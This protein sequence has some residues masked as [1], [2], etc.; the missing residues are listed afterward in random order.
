MLFS[1]CDKTGT[2][3]GLINDCKGVQVNSK[4]SDYLSNCSTKM[5]GILWT[6][7]SFLFKMALLFS[8]T[9][10][11]PWRVSMIHAILFS[12]GGEISVCV[13]VHFQRHPMTSNLFSYENIS[14]PPWSVIWAARHFRCGYLKWKAK[15]NPQKYMSAQPQNRKTRDT[16]QVSFASFPVTKNSSLWWEKNIFCAHRD[17]WVVDT[18]S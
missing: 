14:W 5:F 3:S 13:A 15:K 7:K 17:R 6:I 11:L 12:G 8:W 9:M 18:E 10:L 4:T 2:W 1:Q 16:Q